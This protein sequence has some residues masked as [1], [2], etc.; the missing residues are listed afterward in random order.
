MK[1]SEYDYGM[2]GLGTMGQNLVLNMSDHGYSVI[3]YDKSSDQV[4]TMQENA[5]DKNIYAT[6]DIHEFLNG[7]K[8]PRV[9]MMLVPAGD[10]VDY[11]IEE[12]IPLLSKNDLIMDC[13]NSYFEDTNRRI[14]ELEKHEIHFMGVGISGGELGA[15][16]GPSIMP[17]GPKKVY[18]RV[19]KMLEDV[20][21]KVNNA[22]C[23]TWLGPG[24][25]GH[26]VKMVHNGIE[27]GIMQIIS[28]AY[29]LMKKC[30]GL[31]NDEI[32]KVFETWNQGKLHSYL[33]EITAN[34]FTQKDEFSDK[35][36]ID[37]IVD[38]A[39]QKGT[40]AWTSED[41][42]RLQVPIP[43]I[44]I[45]VSMRDLSA[46]RNDRKDAHTILRRPKKKFE[47]DTHALIQWLEDA[48]YFSIITTYSQGMALL[49]AA[50]E[51]YNYNLNLENIA[52][53]WRGGCIIRAALLEDIRTA[54]LNQPE[55][56]NLMWSATF[57]NK[58]IQSQT[59]LRK[60]IQTG[61]HYGIPIPAMMGAVAYFDSYS[62]GW[63]PMNL[64]QAQ[65]DNFGAHT[66]ARLDREG[67]FHT[68]WKHIQ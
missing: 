35:R 43:V 4:K 23:V 27:Y 49:Q 39:K 48:L 66:Y 19:S 42:M 28:E 40:G 5:K 18:K 10:I 17:G 67:I 47:E 12:L 8:S 7:L 53:I 33:I 60:V 52:A 59:D 63:L 65:R 44:D 55:L 62:S 3:G 30:A 21:A 20:S 24:S 34:I 11:V 31:N 26:Y 36:I 16:N 54:Y 15:R 51:K 46:R 37:L 22:P 50:S 41:A 6:T 38:S 2:I 57:A 61:V 64:I 14:A 25:A 13:G 45:A 58:L 56:S 1:D 32:H 68:Q 29:H 9:I